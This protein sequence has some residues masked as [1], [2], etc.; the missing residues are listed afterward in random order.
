MAKKKKRVEDVERTKD[1]E[2]SQTAKRG[3]GG[4]GRV[5]RDGKVHPLVECLAA[6][7]GQNPPKQIQN[8]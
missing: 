8:N 6:W 4:Y 5:V 2:K 1:V 7:E 3:D